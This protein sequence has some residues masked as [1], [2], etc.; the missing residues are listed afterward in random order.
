MDVIGKVRRMKLRDK[1]SN[2]YPRVTGMSPLIWYQHH[3]WQAMV[4]V[5]FE[6]VGSN[7]WTSALS[8]KA[9]ILKPTLWVVADVSD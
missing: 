7:T 4:N 1:L 5:G 3:F 6:A 8:S 2:R 9:P